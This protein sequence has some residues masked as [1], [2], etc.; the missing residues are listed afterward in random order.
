LIFWVQKRPSTLPLS[1]SPSGVGKLTIHEPGMYA[2]TASDL[3]QLGL[4]VDP[5]KLRL[6]NL[7]QPQRLWF[8]GQGKDLALYFYGQPLDSPYTNE[9]VYFLTIQG[10]DLPASI[11]VSNLQ[12]ITTLP[13][14]LHLEENTLYF[15]K[16]EPER[17][18]YWK[19]L[20]AP[21]TDTYEFTLAHLAEG[22]GILRASFFSSTEAPNN[23]PDHHLRLLVNDSLIVDQHWDGRGSQTFE[24]PLPPGTLQEGMNSLTINLPG[25]TGVV[26]E[27]VLLD[28]LE[29]QFPQLLVA[30]NDRV[31]FTGSGTAVELDEFRSPPVVFDLSPAGG[32]DV[33]PFE[34]RPTESMQI[35]TE[36]GH[37][38]FAVGPNGF[39]HPAISPAQLTPDRRM[40]QA[41]YIAVGPADLLEPLQLLLDYRQSLGLTT[42]AIPIE[43][44]YDQFGGGIAHPEAIRQFLKYAYENWETAPEYLLLVGDSTYDPRRYQ[45]SSDIN[46]VPSFFRFTFYGGE[47]VSDILFAQLDE[48]LLPDLAVGRI[49][50]RTPEQVKTVVDKTLAYERASVSGTSKG[51][52]RGIL[53]IA[54][55][56]EASFQGDAETFLSYFPEGYNAVLLVPPP[57]NTTAPAQIMDVLDEG[58]LFMSYFGHGS[59][60]MLGKDRIF[61]VEDGAALANGDKLPIMINI[62]CLAG[63]FTHPEAESL[64]ETMLWNPDGGAVAALS[65]TSLTTPGD[66]AF[67]SKAL[68]NALVQNP[69]ATLGQLLLTAQRTLPVENGG[70]REVMDTFLLFGDPALELP[71][72]SE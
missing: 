53:A 15:P 40:V 49:P 26:V 39:L 19:S 20:N 7:G 25:D 70:V 50:A 59:I 37:L 44:V 42:L 21:K 66:Q 69:E 52:A 48:D 6:F 58:V 3:E 62:T 55:G 63:L 14:P 34:V 45:T 17:T 68:V 35:A 22:E 67:L 71:D 41:A 57:G 56:Q 5:A 27:T 61:S 54:D 72:L 23:N 36:A 33:T 30:E 4:P 32:G 13:F 28:W 1:I 12:A 38:Y 31:G 16:A 60:T 24:A 8:S 10:N 64:T 51:W 65:A 46:R 43:A 11:T 2:L 18:W 9:N 29:V 47:T